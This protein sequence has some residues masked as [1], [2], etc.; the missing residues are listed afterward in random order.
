MTQHLALAFVQRGTIIQ[1]RMILILLHEDADFAVIQSRIHE[2]W[3][4][5]VGTT[6]GDALSYTTVCFDTFPRPSG[7]DRQLL[8]L[9]G[10]RYHDFRANLMKSKDEGLTKTYNRF[11]DPDERDAGILELRRLHAAIDRVVLDAYGWRDL[12]PRLDFILNYDDEDD[13]GGS[14]D[15]KKPWRYRWIDEDRDEILAR[16]LELNRT[17]AEEEAQSARVAPGPKRG[18]KTGK[19]V[20]VTSPNLFDVQELTE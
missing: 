1:D 5:M 11:H 12:Q 19:S 7:E 6:L 20:P 13:E 18:R 9:A 14:N 17:R 16:L 8:Q 15:R 10:A 3:L 4:R 2:V